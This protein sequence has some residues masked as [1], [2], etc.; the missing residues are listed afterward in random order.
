MKYKTLLLFLLGLSLIPSQRIVVSELFTN[1]GCGPCVSA[2]AEL[3]RL[4]KLY[5]DS[6][7][8]IRFHMY[9]PS[10]TDP[11]Y[12]ANP[13]ENNARRRYYFNFNYVPHLVVDGDTND[14]SSYESRITSEFSNPSPAELS[15]TVDYDTITRTGYVNYKVKAT[16]NIPYQKLRLRTVITESYVYYT[17]PNG[18]PVHHQALRDMIPDTLGISISLVSPPDSVYGSI[19]FTINS[20]WNVNN[21][22]IVSFLQTDSIVASGSFRKR[23]ILQGAKFRF[24]PHLELISDTIFEI[25]GNNNGYIDPGE[26]AVIFART[27]NFFGSSDTVKYELISSDPYISII[28]GLYVKTNVFHYDTISNEFEPLSF[29]ISPSTPQG[30]LFTILLKMGVKS[31][32]LN[33]YNSIYDTIKI[34]AGTPTIIFSDGFESG[35]GEWVTG[36]LGHIY[37]SSNEIHSGSYSALVGVPPPGPEPNGDDWMYKE[38]T[39]PSDPDYIYVDFWVKRGTEDAITYDWQRAQLLNSTGAVLQ[40]FY[41]V[42]ANDKEWKHLFYD[43]SS[44]KGQTVRVR[45]LTHGDGYTDETWQYIDDF[46][47]LTY[48]TVGIDEEIVK[49]EEMNNIITGELRFSLVKDAFVNVKLFDITGKK[50]AEE[51]KR[52]NAGINSF[53]FKKLNPGVYFLR[54]E[55]SGKDFTKKVIFIR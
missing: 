37:Q 36:G 14:A 18:D 52:M 16:D 46:R 33:N 48:K 31:Q 40:T 53:S 5:F 54:I 7:A 11:F 55:T 10:S 35:L 6:L 25:S 21:C 22:E 1:T 32:F 26:N 47:I 34:I 29:S 15:F 20:S 2:N 51:K 9:W 42:C 13:S 23:P 12:T 39:L 38:I 44:R 17:G 41:N 50:V 24:S 27:Q 28:N 8:I 43:I 30:H 45:F 4:S 19:P 3:T 49:F